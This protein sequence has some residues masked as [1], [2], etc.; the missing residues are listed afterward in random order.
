MR[1]SS[2]KNF[3]PST[4]TGAFVGLAYDTMMIT[5]LVCGIGVLPIGAIYA[6]RILGVALILRE[7]FFDIDIE[8][9]FDED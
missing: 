7:V 1:W 9:F 5:M 2:L 3:I 6:I 4:P 8:E